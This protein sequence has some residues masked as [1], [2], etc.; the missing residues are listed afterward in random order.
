MIAFVIFL[1]LFER[2]IYSLFDGLL[3]TFSIFIIIINVNH[4]FLKFLELKILQFSGKISYSIYLI[5]WPILIFFNY[6][7]IYSNSYYTLE[8]KFLLILIIYF[9]SYL[10]FQFIEEKFRYSPQKKLKKNIIQKKFL[11]VSIIFSLALQTLL[12]NNK[13]INRGK[14]IT[15][16]EPAREEISFP[17][18]KLEDDIVLIG[19]SMI[20]QFYNYFQTLNF[21]TISYSRGGCPMLPNLQE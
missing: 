3:V 9:I 7:T 10:S 1:D 11:Y 2:N 8:T 20:K 6:K 5:H 13:L 15:K 17:G 19:D 16:L 4:K 21:K 12:I 14:K 18:N